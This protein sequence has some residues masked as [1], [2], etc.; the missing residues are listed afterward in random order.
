M[1]LLDKMLIKFSIGKETATTYVTQFNII[2][3]RV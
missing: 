3:R 1:V 2:R